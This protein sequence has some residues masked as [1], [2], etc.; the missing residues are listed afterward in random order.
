MN[1]APAKPISGSVSGRPARVLRTVSMTKLERLDGFEF[2]QAIDVGGRAD[3]IVQHRPL[4]GR[5]LQV[6]A[7][8]FEDQQQVGED[9]GRIDAE[10][11]DRGEHDLGGEVGILAQI[12]KRGRSPQFAILG[13]I[14]AGLP[15][16]PDGRPL[17]R[18]AA[19]GLHQEAIG[20]FQGR[21]RT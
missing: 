10:P 15:H 8:R 16:Q 2:Q 19:D 20:A 13:H 9:D 12:E 17:D 11:L 5:E 18:L 3:R 1:G 21:H 7:H 4:A 6:D 14:A